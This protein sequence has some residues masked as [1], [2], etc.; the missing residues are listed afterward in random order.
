VTKQGCRAIDK[1]PTFRRL[2]RVSLGDACIPTPGEVFNDQ[3]HGRAGTAG[4]Q[5]E[6]LVR[7]RAEER[8]GGMEDFVVTAA[9]QDERALLGSQDFL[10]SN[11]SSLDSSKRR[12]ASA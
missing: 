4:S 8:L 10:P 2:R 11:S 7:D 1:E 9:Q 3:F 5:V 6:I 12:L